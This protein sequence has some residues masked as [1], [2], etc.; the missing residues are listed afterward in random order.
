MPEKRQMHLGQQLTR[1]GR[2]SRAG[3]TS[4]PAA[5]WLGIFLVLPI[6][7]IL[8]ISFLTR[9]EYGGVELPFTFDSY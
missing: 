6:A 7:A 8:A 3:I 1:A 9:G 4:G 2:W 5:L